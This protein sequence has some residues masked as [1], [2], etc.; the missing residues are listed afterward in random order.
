MSSRRNTP[1]RVARRR[2]ELRFEQCLTRDGFDGA[3]SIL[4]HEHSPHGLVH[5]RTEGRILT[6][7]VPRELKR[8]HFRTRKLSDAALHTC[9]PVLS[10]KRLAIGVQKTSITDSIYRANGDA[11]E[12]SFVLSG[13]GVVRSTFGDLAF[14]P[15][16][17][18]CIPKGVVHRVLIEEPIE[19]FVIECRGLHIPK[20]F[21][22]ELGQLR[23]DAPYSHRDFRR[24]V[25]EGPRDEGIR[26]V[27]IQ[28]NGDAHVFA[29]QHSLLDA[30]GWD[31]TVYPW[32]FPILAFQ[33][34]VSSVHL[35]PT[36]HGTFAADGTLICSFVPRPL[37]F[38]ADAI[39]CPYPHASVDVD[40]VI[41]YVS[42]AFGSRSGIEVG[43]MS[44]HPSGI[45]H[46]PQPGRYAASIGQKHA[47]ELAVMLD[48]YDTISSRARAASEDPIQAS[49]PP[50]KRKTPQRAKLNGAWSGVPK[51]SRRELWSASAS[52]NRPRD[53]HANTATAA[54][55]PNDRGDTAPP[56]DTAAATEAPPP[57]PA[58]AT[59][60][61]RAPPRRCD[62]RRAAEAPPPRRR[63]REA[64]RRTNTGTT[65]FSFVHAKRAS[66][67]HGAVHRADR[68]L[69]SVSVAHRHEREAA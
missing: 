49:S 10:S 13:E 42:G 21:R 1:R 22:N 43:S 63:R 47:D 3:Y 6:S 7:A 11:D 53:R 52:H 29:A 19:R 46:G 38:G 57:P 65:L 44:L 18:V 66:V 35:P 16:D 2:G 33:P 56:A 8:R 32:A 4:Y 27:A 58:A 39:P 67:E 48:C 15:G 40:E 24:P 28:R 64:R 20:Q 31:G 55:R 61:R 5:V 34:R 17:Y 26:E 45:P 59:P 30:V 62:H 25:F 14:G 51:V 54:T 50:V 68:L 12:L 37:D 41:Y 36:W 9:A 23:M 69:R 60:H